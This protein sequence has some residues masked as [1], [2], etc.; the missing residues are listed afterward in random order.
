MPYLINY[1]TLHKE[2]QWTGYDN[3]VGQFLSTAVGQYQMSH[4]YVVQSYLDQWWCK[5]WSLIKQFLKEEGCQLYGEE[6]I[7]ISDVYPKN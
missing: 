3:L 4:R 6:L 5:T 7:I 1:D 2:N